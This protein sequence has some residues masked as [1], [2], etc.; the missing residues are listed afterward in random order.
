V[1]KGHTPGDLSTIP[2]HILCSEHCAFSTH[3]LHHHTRRQKPTSTTPFLCACASLLARTM[4]LPARA[5]FARRSLSA[6]ALPMLR[7]FCLHAFVTSLLRAI[8]MP[9]PCACS[10]L[11]I[12]LAMYVMPAF[13][14][15]CYH[16]TCGEILSLY[17][18]LFLSLSS[19]QPPLSAPFPGACHVYIR[20][21]CISEC[22][23]M[24]ACVSC[25]FLRA[26]VYYVRVC[27]GVFA[28]VCKCASLCVCVCVCTC[29]C[30]CA[31]A[32]VRA[33]ANAMC[34][35][36]CK[37]VG[38]CQRAGVRV[39]VC[40]FPLYL[41]YVDR[42]PTSATAS[43]SLHLCMYMTR[44]HHTHIH[45]HT[46]SRV[47]SC[48]FRSLCMHLLPVSMEASMCSAIRRVIHE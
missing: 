12:V 34:L 21:M 11:H 32:C 40:V 18:M 33:C 41:Q 20:V 30:V 42:N 13:F 24:C 16:C 48:L 46:T 27:L 36:A 43:H 15:G 7:A 31:S 35:C 2:L 8:H 23:C 3:S 47:C 14:S 4:P 29:A 17:P 38:V 10:T 6:L 44:T 28:C 19:A 25:E 37:Y 1:L 39:S 45:T 22:M 26:G 5:L 9:T